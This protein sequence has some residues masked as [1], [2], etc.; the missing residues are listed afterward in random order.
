VRTLTSEADARFRDLV[1]RRRDEAHRLGRGRVG[2]VFV[3]DMER[4]GFAE[5]TRYF[6]AEVRRGGLVVDLRG[7]AGGNCSELLLSKLQQRSL[8]YETPRYGKAEPWPLAPTTKAVLLVDE[9]SCSDAEVAAHGFRA[10]G[11]GVVVG[12]RTW[13]GVC[14]NEEYAELVDGSSFAVPHFGC[15]FEGGVAETLENRGV[16]PDVEVDFPPQAHAKGEDPQLARAVQIAVELLEKAGG[17]KRPPGYTKGGGGGG[18]GEGKAPWPFKERVFAP[19]TPAPEPD[20]DE[21]WLKG[22]AADPRR[23]GKKNKGGGGGG[24][25]GKGNNKR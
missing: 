2:Y 13:G 1:R 24:G 10:L 8:G 17:I 25:G 23:G 18:G 11:L 16:A 15:W 12:Q 20:P 19:M 3:P 21:E 22:T 6:Q 5:F 9:N 7:N 4:M 14:G